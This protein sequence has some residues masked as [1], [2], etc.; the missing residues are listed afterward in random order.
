MHQNSSQI[1][2]YLNPHE[3]GN[4]RTAKVDYTKANRSAVKDASS[5]NA[6]KKMNE[7]VEGENVRPGL[8]VLSRQK[9]GGGGPQPGTSFGGPRQGPTAAPAGRGHAPQ[10]GKDFVR[11]NKHAAVTNKPVPQAPKV[12]EHQKIMG[13]QVRRQREPPISPESSLTLHFPFHPIEFIRRHSQCQ[14]FQ[15]HT[16][17]H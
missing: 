16:H 3:N 6:I 17:F 4:R 15:L 1:A 8:A 12:D 9:S 10:T 2:G 5:M 13:K 14:A 7:V 11:A